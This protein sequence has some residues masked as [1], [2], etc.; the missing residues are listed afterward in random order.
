MDPS[1]FLAML[2]QDEAVLNKTGAEL[3]GRETIE[4]ANAGIGG[5]G[6]ESMYA[7]LNVD[8]RRLAYANLR[9][10]RAGSG[11]QA[12]FVR[13]AGTSSHVGGYI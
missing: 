13:L 12:E 4:R 7:L 9:Q 1:A 2:H 8:G 10:V 6:R 11:L 5:G 3:I